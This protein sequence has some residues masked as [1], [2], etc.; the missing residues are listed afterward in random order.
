MFGFPQDARF[1]QHIVRT[2]TASREYDAF[3]EIVRAFE[4]VSRVH[5]L[6][7]DFSRTETWRKTA[8]ENSQGRSSQVW[9]P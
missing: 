4:G 1:Q 7:I 9:N 5:L 2:S 6:T 8:S 3:A